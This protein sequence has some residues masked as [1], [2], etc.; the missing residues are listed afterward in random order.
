VKKLP[1]SQQ[2]SIRITDK[3]VARADAL[4]APLGESSGR[5]VT[6]ADVWREALVAGLAELEKRRAAKR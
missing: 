1:E 5:V 2:I 6:R 4:I 3:L